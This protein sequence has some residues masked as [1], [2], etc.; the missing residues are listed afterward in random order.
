MRTI[1]ILAA[2]V[3]LSVAGGVLF[4][5]ALLDISQARYEYRLVT[6]TEAIR[7]VN[8]EGWRVSEHIRMT[9]QAVYLYRT[10]K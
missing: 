5:M 3:V 1:A 4:G 9:Q 6:P 7:L 8:D 2:V 10:R